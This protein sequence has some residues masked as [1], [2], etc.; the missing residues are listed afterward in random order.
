MQ[1]SASSKYLSKYLIHEELGRG[2]FGTVYR[3][4]DTTLDRVVALRILDP[5]L[6][7]E[8]GFMTRC[9]R[10]IVAVA[11]LEH[12]NILPVYEV[13][14]AEGRSFI[15]MAYLP[16][17][18]LDRLLAAEGPWPAEQ[19]L[20]ILAQIA[21]ALDAAHAQGL[22]HG[23][24]VP[25]HVLVS[26][27]GHVMVMDFGLGEASEQTSGPLL[28]SGLLSPAGDLD[29]ARVTAPEVLASTAPVG[30][31]TDRYALAV[32]AYR[33]LSGQWPFPGRTAAEVARATL[34][35]PPAV[36]RSLNG[37]I[38]EELAAVLLVALAKDPTQ[39]YP[40]GAALVA[41][42]ADA[43][44]GRPW[45][46]IGLAFVPVPAG[47]FTFGEGAAARVIELLRF[48]MGVYPVTV[49]Q[50]VA[51]VAATGYVTQAEAEGWG[52]AFDGVTWQEVQGAC[53]RA[54]RGPGSSSEGRERHPVVQVSCH[55]AAA[56]CDWAG[57]ALPD[58]QQ[59]EK[60]ARGPLPA[61][62][63]VST[64]EG[65]GGGLYPWGD[66]WRAEL[67]HHADSGL[68]D[69]VPVDQHTGDASPY[70][71]H[72]LAG[73]VWEWTTSAYDAAGAYRV[74]RGGAWPHDGRY[75]RATFRYYA[76][77]GYRSDALGFRCIRPE[78]EK[79]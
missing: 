62:S 16:S 27:D 14:D 19:S 52:L 29:L 12:P 15:A 11:A 2:G 50:F 70:G 17:P 58:E 55:D 31:P 51:F 67:C 75:L 49:A 66:H 20:L 69:T 5:L 35:G 21:D 43:S 47:P 46:R 39:R 77:P 26:D 48:E 53:W 42:L 18:P 37:E 65:R 10:A 22:H 71:V 4:T 23:N 40:T 25:A 60:A 74:L 34:A 28:S 79:T 44:A 32:L 64:G 56:F 78:Q 36:S 6:T 9:R 72:G 63:P 1:D 57:V 76:L 73:N 3:A 30:P 7:R 38:G 41:A 68:R 13:G 59:W 33:L 61:P 54:P 45:Q 8:P 24:L